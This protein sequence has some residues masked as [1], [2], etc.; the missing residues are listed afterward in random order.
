MRSRPRGTLAGMTPDFS[1]EPA[2]DSCYSCGG[3]GIVDAVDWIACAACEK[4]GRVLDGVCP[5][6]NGS[7]LQK[8]EVK[9]LCPHCIGKKAVI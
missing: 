6:C 2:D 9:S 3:S 5:C 8:V 7:G 1:P 4:T